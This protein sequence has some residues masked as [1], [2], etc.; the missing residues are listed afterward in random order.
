MSDPVA[1]VRVARRDLHQASV[2]YRGLLPACA[3]Q[4]LGWNSR[5]SAGEDL[6][7][8]RANL[9]VA[10]KPLTEREALWVKRARGEGLPVVIDLCDNVFID[11]YAGQGDEIATRFLSTAKAA[12]AITVPTAGLRDTVIRASGLSGDRV[13]IVPDIVETPALVRRQRKLVGEPSGWGLAACECLGRHLARLRRNAPPKL[14]WFGH[15][16]AGY[17]NFGLSDLL[18]FGPALEKAAARHGAELW[19]VSNHE[20][21]F[22]TLASKLPIA[23][24]YFEWSPTVVDA[25]LPAV[26]VCLVPNSLDPFSSTKSANRALKALSGG[27]PVVATPT[28]AY[29]GLEAGI[30]LDDPTEGV[31]AY[32]EDRRLRSAH[33]R[34]ARRAIARAHSMHALN[35]AMRRVIDIVRSNGKC[36]A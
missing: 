3:L 4:N 8:A 1:L 22:R 11:G 7:D 20:E 10:V 18:L 13:V 34:E 31:L 30:W 33:L 5:V 25:L 23:T 24:R 12:V 27:V 17:A 2:R 15:H 14:L 28:S 36:I 29:A 19:V 6:P 16:G 9:V 35:E 26:D 21:R 32:L